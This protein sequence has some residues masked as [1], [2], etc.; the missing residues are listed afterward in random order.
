MSKKII[1][2]GNVIKDGDSGFTLLEIILYTAILSLTIGFVLIGVYQIIDSKAGVLGRV[3][4]EEEAN[5]LIK[6]IKW[7]LTGVNVINQPLTATTSTTLSV[8][9]F[10][11]SAN[12]VVISLSGSDIKISYA[13]QPPV[14]LNSEDVAVKKLVF[15]N[16]SDNNNSAIKVELLIEYK[17]NDLKL[18]K[19]STQIE[20]TVYLRK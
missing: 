13:G 2:I 20:T 19:P 14:V 7:A 4:V 18:I 16:I 5:F 17:R 9:K 10:N 6:K 1:K 11:F 15:E 3:S 8:D 12:P